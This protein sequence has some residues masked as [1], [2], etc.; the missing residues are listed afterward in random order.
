[1]DPIV[2]KILMV[3]SLSDTQTQTN[4][5]IDKICTEPNGNLHRYLS[6]MDTFTQFYASN[7]SSVSVLASVQREHTIT[8]W[9]LDIYSK[10]I[11]FTIFKTFSGDC[12]Q[13]YFSQI[14]ESQSPCLG[15]L[16]LDQLPVW[17]AG[18]M[19]SPGSRRN[20]IWRRDDVINSLVS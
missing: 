5:D 14:C 6:S 10:A 17:D 12:F 19:T 11:F 4:T 20:W 16:M 13:Q 18:T 1:M 2:F 8:I 9:F 15:F 3:N 7:F